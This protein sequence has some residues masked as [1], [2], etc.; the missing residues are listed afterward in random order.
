MRPKQQSPYEVHVHVLGPVRRFPRQGVVVY[1]NLVLIAAKVT[2]RAKR[3]EGG[4][5]AREDQRTQS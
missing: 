1:G 2:P 5:Q 4:N 3:A